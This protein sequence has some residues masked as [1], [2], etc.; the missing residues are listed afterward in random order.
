MSWINLK[1]T[2]IINGAMMKKFLIIGL[3]LGFIGCAHAPVIVK[4]FVDPQYGMTK[5]QMI[6]LIGKPDSIEIYKKTDQ[7]RVEFYMYERKYQSSQERV[8]VCLIGN[9]V[10]GWGKT[11]YEDHIAPDDIRIK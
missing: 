9:K 4:P 5:L 3:C 7:T 10:V 11:Y 8:P 1:F 6:A 2:I